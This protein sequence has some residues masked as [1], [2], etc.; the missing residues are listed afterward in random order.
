MEEIINDMDLALEGVAVS[1][2]NQNIQRGLAILEH[3]FPTFS[4]SKEGLSLNE[5]V[6][7]IKNYCFLKGYISNEAILELLASYRVSITR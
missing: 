2:S 7:E 4:Y 1:N 5:K 6:N 3:I